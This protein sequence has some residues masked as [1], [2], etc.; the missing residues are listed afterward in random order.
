VANLN[1][2]QKPAGMKLDGRTLL[3]GAIVVIAALFILPRLL[4]T[5]GTDVNNPGT[6]TQNQPNQDQP[7]QD[8][9]PNVNLGNPVTAANIDRD[10]CP[11]STASSFNRNQ[12]VY[13]VAPGSDIPAGTAVFVSLYRGGQ[14]IEDAPEITADQDY[15]NTCLNFVFEPVGGAFQPGNYEAEFVINGNAAQSVTFTIE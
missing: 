15:T 11:T 3:I 5:S 4:N 10:G 12:D 6:T 7:N 2:P 13:V 14:R 8:L 1:N 9:N